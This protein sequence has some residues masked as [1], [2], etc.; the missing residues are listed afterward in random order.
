MNWLNYSGGRDWTDFP[1]AAFDS[2]RSLGRIFPS[3]IAH[4]LHSSSVP[5]RALEKGATAAFECSCSHPF[6][7]VAYESLELSQEGGQS[8]RAEMLLAGEAEL[9]QFLPDR[10]QRLQL[11]VRGVGKSGADHFLRLAQRQPGGRTVE[12]VR[13]ESAERVGKQRAGLR[14]LRLK[15][16]FRLADFPQRFRKRLPE[17]EPSGISAQPVEIEPI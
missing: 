2:S 17:P 6:V 7:E 10:L 12:F 15:S 8:G 9:F 4:S 3:G 14:R 1:A 5:T 13:Q 16:R 11:A